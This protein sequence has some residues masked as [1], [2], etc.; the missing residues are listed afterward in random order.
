MGKTVEYKGYVIESA[1]RYL[2]AWAKWQLRI[3]IA[4]DGHRGV[5]TRECSSE[6]LFATE[7]EADSRGIALAQR[8]IDGKVADLSVTDLE[9]A[10]RDSTFPQVQFRTTFPTSRKLKGRG[11]LLDL[12]TDGSRIQSSVTVEPGVWL[13][14]RLY[15]PDLNKTLMVESARV[16]WVSGQIFGVAFVR[17]TEREQQRLGQVIM[18]LMGG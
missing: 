14:L 10:D 18:S 2:A 13:E 12:S 11:V 4:F 16:Q 17:I 3:L 9:T 15:V 7:Q 8:L 6:I 1:P 5:P